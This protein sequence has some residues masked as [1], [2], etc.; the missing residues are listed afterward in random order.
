MREGTGENSADNHGAVPAQLIFINYYS[1]GTL[2][3]LLTVPEAL[4]DMDILMGMRDKERQGSTTSP[5][6]SSARQE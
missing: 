4:R 5:R 2:V 1:A 6:S 3:H